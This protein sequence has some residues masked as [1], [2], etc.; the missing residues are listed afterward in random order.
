MTVG[1]VA[2]SPEISPLIL[3]AKRTPIG[4]YLGGL[5]GLSA[6]ELGRVAARAAIAE[7]G[8]APTDVDEAYVGCVLQAGVGQAPAR[9]VALGA[10]MP[11]SSS[12]LTVNMVCGSGLR[13]VMLAATAIRAGEIETAL[14]GGV[15]SMS[16]A[17][18]LLRDG[19]AGW[20]FGDAPLVDAMIHDGLRCGVGGQPM[21]ELADRMAARL[22]VAR[23]EQD[24]FALESHRRAVAA[25]RAGAFA[26]EVAEVRIPARKGGETVVQ[27]DEIPREDA[28]PEALARLA[29]AFGPEGSVTA[30]N[31]SALADGAAMLVLANPEQAE[32]LGRPPLARVL[33]HATAGLAPEDLFE[34]PALAIEAAVMRAG[35]ALAD[36][37]IF[38]VNEAFAAQVVACARALNLDP[39]RLNPDGGA[40]ALGHPIGASGARVLATLAHGLRRRDKTFGVAALCLGG[41][42]AVAVVIERMAA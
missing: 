36:I 41:G 17:P 2:R 19:R 31:A 14:A 4:R 12:A 24:A 30:G 20:K 5:S 33:A 10:G 16:R 32:A 37:D 15:E 6:T 26:D 8:L 28:T 9:Q 27:R 7:S 23:S 35:L 25:W 29:P 18:H 42:Q 21:G 38:E 1:R 3:S 34:A 39:E 40:I 13:A 22:G 11:P